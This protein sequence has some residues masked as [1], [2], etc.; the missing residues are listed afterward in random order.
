MGIG[1]ELEYTEGTTCSVSYGLVHE[2]AQTMPEVFYD[3]NSEIRIPSVL[4]HLGFNIHFKGHNR[5]FSKHENVLIRSNENPLQCYFTDV[6]RGWYRN[7]VKEVTPEGKIIY[8]K[9]SF[10]E[11]ANE[12]NKY[13]VLQPTNLSDYIDEED[14]LFIDDFGGKSP[15]SECMKMGGM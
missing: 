9:H 7:A 10:H 3:K 5:N 8:D 2:T 4:H 13:E 15:L 6:Y 11:L 14:L 1:K 12:Y